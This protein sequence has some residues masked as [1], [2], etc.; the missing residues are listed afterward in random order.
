MNKVNYTTRCE[1][2]IAELK[3]IIAGIKTANVEDPTDPTYMAKSTRATKLYA[4]GKERRIMHLV[5]SLLNQLGDSLKLSEDDA[6]TLLLITKPEEERVVNTG[7]A[8]HE[9]DDILQLLMSHENLN[10]KKLNDKCEK[11]GLRCDFTTGK[12]VKA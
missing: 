6:A 5:L 8:I 9:G 12:I 2:K 7:I 11:L 3:T 10:K 4:R 1:E